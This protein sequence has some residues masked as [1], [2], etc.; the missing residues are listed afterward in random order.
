LAAV[1]DDPT[2]SEADLTKAR[3]DQRL[4]G[5]AFDRARSPRPSDPDPVLAGL[6]GFL[7]E[8][9]SRAFA[10]VTLGGSVGIDRAKSE[11]RINAQSGPEEVFQ[12]YLEGVFNGITFGGAEAFVNARAGEGKGLGASL[13]EG[14]K[15]LGSSAI[16]L[17]ELAILADPKKSSWEKAEA[18]ASLVAKWAGLAAGGVAGARAA[19]ARFEAW[20]SGRA[21]PAPTIAPVETPKTT[22]EA[23][24]VA[25]TQGAEAGTTIDP[26]SGETVHTRSGRS[27]HKQLADERRA[28]GDFDL[29]NEPIRDAQG[30]PIEVPTRVDLETGTPVA[31]KGTQTT[32]PDAVNFER[33]LILD[34]KP[35]TRPISRDRQEII[36]FI[37]AY[38]ERTGRMPRYIAITRYD[39]SGVP[40]RTDLYKP[41]TFLPKR[42]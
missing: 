9:G 26:K 21:V 34:D 13:A 7:D 14:F 20:R 37:T 33:D 6:S 12:A 15:Q 36:R 25:R 10:L 29:V 32:R 28:A 17:E 35:L 18:G 5:L 2:S 1:L 23:E 22:G 8:A 42:K 11:G 27:T 16:A 24:A 4:T 19:R 40:I 30:K 41:E 31:R 3:L 39:R 38:Q